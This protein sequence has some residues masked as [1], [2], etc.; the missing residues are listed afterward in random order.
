MFSVDA[1]GIIACGN[2]GYYLRDAEGKQLNA[3]IYP[4]FVEEVLNLS[5]DDVF[6]AMK[7]LKPY[8]NDTDLLADFRANNGY[9]IVVLVYFFLVYL[10]SKPFFA[11]FSPLS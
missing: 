9:S 1:S 7:T 6:S 10:S 11:L 5:I 4:N 8:A 2:K 3:V